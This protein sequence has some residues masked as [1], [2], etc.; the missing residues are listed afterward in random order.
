MSL[1]DTEMTVYEATM[2]IKIVQVAVIVVHELVY[3]CV[4]FL[5][6]FNSANFISAA[7]IA[8]AKAKIKSTWRNAIPYIAQR[9][10]CAFLQ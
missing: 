2:Y 4:N 8:I 9:P 3:G 7:V 6:K 1:S 5:W 10:I